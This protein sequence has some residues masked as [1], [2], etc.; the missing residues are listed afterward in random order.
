MINFI[1]AQ[2]TVAIR[3]FIKEWNASGRKFVWIKN[4]QTIMASIKK[5]KQPVPHFV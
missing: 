3:D 1:V 2:L 5:A 4:T